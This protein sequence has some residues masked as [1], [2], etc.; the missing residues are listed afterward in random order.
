MISKYISQPF[1]TGR[2]RSNDRIHLMVMTV[3][4][5]PPINSSNNLFEKNMSN[6]NG[7]YGYNDDISG[8]FSAETDNTYNKNKCNKNILGGSIPAVLHSSIIVVC[9]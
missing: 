4:V 7:R 3:M 6:G 8:T 5:P 2:P 9:S 1:K